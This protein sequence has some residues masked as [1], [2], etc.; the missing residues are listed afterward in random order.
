MTSDEVSQSSSVS[1]AQETYGI[2]GNWF[3]MLERIV[4]A[5][6]V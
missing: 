5:T 4:N 6:R 3:S 2:S 1:H